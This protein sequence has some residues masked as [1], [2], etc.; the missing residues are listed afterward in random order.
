KSYYRVLAKWYQRMG[1][2]EQSVKMWDSALE[3]QRKY[4]ERYNKLKLQLF[5]QQLETNTYQAA[6]QQ[7][8]A[9]NKERIL[10]GA[11]IGI[12]LLSSI[13]YGVMK[14]R[15]ERRIKDLKLKEAEQELEI[16]RLQLNEYTQH[17]LHK[18]Q[19]IATLEEQLKSNEEWE[20]VDELKT[21]TLLTNDDW[22]NFRHKFEKVHK[23]FSNRL[24][25]QLPNLTTSE[26]RFIKLTR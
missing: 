2:D 26:Q 18:N 25:A 4:S 3:A 10:Y 1:M 9:K 11:I 7:Q 21:S 23:G 14:R 12:G 22:D 13:F 24:N 17:L 20:L 15:S 8:K 16:T 19:Q 6:L 5:S